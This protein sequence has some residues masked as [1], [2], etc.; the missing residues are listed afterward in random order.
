M[1]DRSSRES[2]K[3]G[4]VA[5]VTAPTEHAQAARAARLAEALRENLRRRKTQSRARRPAGAGPA[6]DEGSDED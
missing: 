1:A 4:R 5:S 2:G 6:P 3:A